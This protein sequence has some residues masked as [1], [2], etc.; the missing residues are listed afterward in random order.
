MDISIG[1]GEGRREVL[2]SRIHQPWSNN[3]RVLIFN[4]TYGVLNGCAQAC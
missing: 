4:R 2:I 3:T 1:E